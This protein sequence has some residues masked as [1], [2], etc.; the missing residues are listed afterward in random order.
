M[1]TLINKE[2]TVMNVFLLINMITNRKN[3]YI[4]ANKIN[5][6]MT[7]LKIVLF[8]KWIIALYALMI[9]KVAKNVLV[10]ITYTIKLA[11]KFVQTDISQMIK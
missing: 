8:V 4:H 2:S 10:V 7:K 1:E 5:K 3:A 6:F 9:F 11:K